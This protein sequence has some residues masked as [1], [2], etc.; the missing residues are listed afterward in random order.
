VNSCT[1]R[2]AILQQILPLAQPSGCPRW[3]MR[4]SCVRV[5]IAVQLRLL[6]HLPAPAAACCGTASV[7]QLK[8]GDGALVGAWAEPEGW[9]RAH[10]FWVNLVF[11][12]QLG[13][14]I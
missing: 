11:F 10:I 1:H 6:W 12:G 7:C 2:V 14:F 5:P 4:S 3:G 8:S 13:W 9:I